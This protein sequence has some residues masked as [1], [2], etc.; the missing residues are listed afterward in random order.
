[1]I[2]PMLKYSFLVY[3]GDYEKFLDDIGKIGVVDV[4]VK[5]DEDSEELKEKYRHVKEITSTIKFLEKRGVEKKKQKSV[6][7]KDVFEEINKLSNEQEEKLQQ[8]N[9]LKKEISLISPW[10]DFSVDTIEKLKDEGIRLRFYTCSSKRYDEQWEREYPIEVIDKKAGN[11]YFVVVER[12]EEEIE[13][14]AEE[15]RAPEKPVSELKHYEKKLEEDIRNIEKQFDKHASQSIKALEEYRKEIWET[16]EYEKVWE[17]TLAEADDKVMILEGWVPEK[18]ADELDKYLEKQ[19]ILY[20]KTEPDPEK[21]KVPILLKNKKFSEKFEML[22]DFYSLPKYNELDLTPFFAPFYMLFFGFC[23]GDAGYGI[24]L[25]IVALLARSKVKTEL[26][27]VMMLIF[28]LGVSTFAFGII[29]G[30]FFGIDLYDT[31]LP[32]YSSLNTYMEARGT[33][34]NQQLFNL[35]LILG[36]L[37][38]IF[39]LFLKAINETIQM[40]WKFALSTIGWIVLIVGGGILFALN[41]FE[42]MPKQMINILLYVVLGIS[43]L[44]IFVLNHPR[45]NVFV[46]IGAGLWNTYNMV[47]G[48]LGDLLSYIRLFALGISSAILG[49][50]FNSIAVSMSGNIPVISIIVMVIILVI[51]HGINLFMSGLGAFVHPLRLTFVEFY[52]NAGFT[53]GGKE[54]RPFRKTGE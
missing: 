39:G 49:Y 48:V 38:I 26:K 22:G 35:S 28:Y 7:G 47:T 46:N 3:H 44:F 29:S 12:G 18:K 50:V 45:R 37:Q 54:Y 19:K 15:V 51:G 4:I 24:L 30:T 41:Y 11:V 31:K 27:K 53:G 13:L 20:I 40:G 8:L 36:G 2:L 52:K 14:D 21:E 23:L 32:V 25:G 1:M 33:D 17:N 34:I 10:G 43:G 9:S 42:M 6:E 5:K 16:T